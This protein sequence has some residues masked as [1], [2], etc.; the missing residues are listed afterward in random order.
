[1]LFRSFTATTLYTIYIIRFRKPYCSTYE[2]DKDNFNY[3]M[4]LL[5]LAAIL[6]LVIYTKW[7]IF[8]L[9]RSYSI[10]LEAFAIIPQLFLLQLMGEVENITSNY[11]VLLG[12]Y[13]LFY[14]FHWSSI[15]KY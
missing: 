2:P 4:Y 14:I 9:L 7:G 6:T 3:L 12:L 11:I 15:T 13:R 10:W 1:M 5:P 8:E